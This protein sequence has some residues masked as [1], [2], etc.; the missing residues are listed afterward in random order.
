[1]RI[2]K[3]KKLNK[4]DTIGIIS[5]ASS[6]DDLTRIEK[7]VKYFEKLGYRVELG[8]NVGKYR[9]YLAG[10]DEGRLKD[11]HSMF[12]NKNVKAIIAVRGGYGSPRLLDKIDYDLIKKNPKIFV[13]Y[14][15]ITVLNN[16]FFKKSGLV[17]FSGPMLAVD[18][19]DNVDAFTEEFFWN[20]V[21][22]TKPIGKTPLPD[23]EKCFSLVR[24]KAEGIVIGGNLAL[25]GSILGTDY[26]PDFD[27]KILF[28]EDI[29]ELPYRVDRLLNQLK[30][31]G[32]F[33]KLSGII[34]GA[35][36]DCNEIDTF[37]R[38]LT[39]GE[40][41]EDYLAD[42]KI[43][44][45]YNFPHGHITKTVTLPIGINIKLNSAKCMVEYC[46]AAVS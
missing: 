17:T 15:D 2:I 40:V 9:G 23:G 12:S 33:K 35:F 13:G 21:T 31:L 1:M 41:I 14:S 8:E 4:K 43:P 30:L 16:A 5:P 7:G 34:L 26:L 29:G 11:I 18:F 22:S 27:K 28:L 20:V 3:P 25:I 36:T 38:T 42:L 37:K 6:P 44:V 45:L 10:A 46:E 19:F 32:A 39:L 24:G